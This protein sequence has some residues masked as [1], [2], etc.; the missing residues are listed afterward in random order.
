MAGAAKTIGAVHRFPGFRSGR[1]KVGRF[2]AGQSGW[3]RAAIAGLP[4]ADGKPVY[5]FHAASLGEYGLARPIIHRLKERCDCHVVVTFFSPTGVAALSAS[6][7]KHEADFI[8]YLPL[9]SA[10]NAS[11]WLDMLRPACAGF[12]VSEYW[13][14]MLA[15]LGRRRIPTF[16]I[17]ALITENAPFFKWYGGLYRH[18]LDSYTQILTLND[19]SRE[20]L[21]RLDYNR[22]TVTGDPLFDNV[23]QVASTPWR[24]EII[25]RFAAGGNVFI[26][27]SISDW[28]DMDLVC[29]LANRHPE[30]KFMFVPHEVT[31]GSVQSIYQGLQS[32]AVNYTDCTPDTDFSGVQTMIVDYVGD[33]AYLYRYGTWAYVGGG[34]TRKLHSIIEAT[35]YGLP[36]AFG[37]EIHRKVTPLELVRREIGQVVTSARELD[38]WFSALLNSDD[39]HMDNIRQRAKAYTESNVGAT[40]KIVNTLLEA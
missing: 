5:W 21:S 15:E 6:P 26:A 1:G 24:N 32:R 19:R 9:D 20:L 39:A 38:E 18:I 22:V 10:G 27:G 23:V 37:P 12:L 4:K 8:G 11:Q 16:L 7:G 25:E 35:V 14:N 33:L 29:S 17:G 40:E 2:V 28:H 31:S 36:V 34:F 30:I 13:P 3:H